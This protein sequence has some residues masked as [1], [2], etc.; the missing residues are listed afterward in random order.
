AHLLSPE[1][2]RQLLDLCKSFNRAGVAQIGIATVKDLGNRSL[3][4]YASDLFRKWKLGHGRQRSD[5]LLLLA[6]PGSSH[7]WGVRVEVGDGLEGI[8]PDGK[9]GALLDERW[10]P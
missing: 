2:T 3:S 9:V 8:L 10:V 1:H 4:A 6:A 7:P 5:G